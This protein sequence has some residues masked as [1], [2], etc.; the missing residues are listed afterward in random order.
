MTKLLLN[1]G[2]N[3]NLLNKT[4]YGESFLQDL[5]YFPHIGGKHTATYKEMFNLL[6]SRLTQ[7]RKNN[8]RNKF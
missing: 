3:I 7:N 2:A 6:N 1:A 5:P 4:A 8:E